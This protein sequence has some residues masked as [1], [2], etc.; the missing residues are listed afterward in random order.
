[1][2]D[3]LGVPILDDDWQSETLTKYHSLF[4]PISHNKMEKLECLNKD[5]IIKL[6]VCWLNDKE[7]KDYYDQIR[8][9]VFLSSLPEINNISDLLEYSTYY[10]YKE[11]TEFINFLV[12]TSN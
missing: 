6:L 7:Y 9:T 1:M 4:C 5:T 2:I 3:T 12:T 11:I 10:M 8:G